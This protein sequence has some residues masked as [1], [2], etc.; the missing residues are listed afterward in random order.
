M[1]MQTTTTHRTH[2]LD[3]RAA[4]TDVLRTVFATPGTHVLKDVTAELDFLEATA[5]DVVS[6][7]SRDAVITR[8][9][10]LVLTIEVR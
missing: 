5:R 2:D 6:I 3:G 1:G 8:T 7:H 4:K 9:S 10:P